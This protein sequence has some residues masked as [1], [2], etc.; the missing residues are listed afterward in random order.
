MIKMKKYGNDYNLLTV[1]ESARFAK[2]TARTIYRWIKSGKIRARQ[3][4]NRKYYIYS[5][6]LEKFLKGKEI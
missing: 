3:E 4:V 2:K 1:L 6:S 5:N